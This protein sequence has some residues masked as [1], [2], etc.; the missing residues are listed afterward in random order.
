MK[1]YIY[2]AV[3]LLLAGCVLFNLS[4]NKKELDLSP[5][6]P[7]EANFFAQESDIQKA[8]YGVY[9][10]LS[11]VYWY[12][13]G[14]SLA[15]MSFAEGDD[16]TTNDANQAFET[17]GQLQ[18]SNGSV[19]YMYSIWY[20]MIARANV[21]LEKIAEVKDGIYSTPNLKTYNQG[22]ALFLR[23]LAYYHLW[24][25]F[26]TSPLRNERVKDASQFTPPN[27]K[28]TELLDQAIKD[29]TAAAGLLP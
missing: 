26:G 19:S 7:T 28:G 11:D 12:N 20:Q 6:G 13:A 15:P 10:K 8:V 25:Y 21:V 29:L 16:I 4:C 2:S 14:S 9:S 18:P 3:F 24:N 17:F 27:T 23:G 1:R 5:H 22:E